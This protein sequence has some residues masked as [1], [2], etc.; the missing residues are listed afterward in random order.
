M[1]WTLFQQI[2]NYE[3]RFWT[4]HFAY[5]SELITAVLIAAATGAALILAGLLASARFA[6]S[7]PG[8]MQ[9]NKLASCAAPGRNGLRSVRGR[10]R[11]PS[12]RDSN[13][14]PL[15]LR[16]GQNPAD[17]SVPSAAAPYRIPLP[18][19]ILIVLSRI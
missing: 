16:H 12:T 8:C 2:P 3:L 15:V 18:I 10:G 14:L 17:Y 9:T 5:T 13:E 7:S 6:H 4:R 11:T 19:I 1:A